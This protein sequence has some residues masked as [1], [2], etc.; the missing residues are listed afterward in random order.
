[1][2]TSV[3]SYMDMFIKLKAHLFI[4]RQPQYNKMRSLQSHSNIC[5]YIY[6]HIC[7]RFELQEGS[8]LLHGDDTSHYRYR[9][10]VA[11]LAV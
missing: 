9:Y 8:F 1:M 6:S 10:D 5:I 7:R 4:Y 3:Y 11:F 2:V